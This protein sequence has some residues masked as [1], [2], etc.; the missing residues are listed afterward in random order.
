MFN[1][2]FPVVMKASTQLQLPMG[3][4]NPAHFRHLL[5]SSPRR[6]GSLFLAQ[7]VESTPNSA[8]APAGSVRPARGVYK[9]RQEST[10]G[11][12]LNPLS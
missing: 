2:C 5:I 12:I 9:T 6:S 8:A 10:P 4:S 7:E 3:P 11:T 1:S